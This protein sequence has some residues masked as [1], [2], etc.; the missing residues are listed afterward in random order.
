MGDYLK[1]PFA[2]GGEI[3]AMLHCTTG[4]RTILTLYLP[5]IFMIFTVNEFVK[6]NVIFSRTKPAAITQRIYF[7][8]SK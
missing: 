3:D 4:G 2:V 8:P 7:D 5:L 6:K 1:I